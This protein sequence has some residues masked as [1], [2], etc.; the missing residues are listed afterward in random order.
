MN[1]AGL[2]EVK[3][4]LAELPQKELVELCLS[5]A[6]YKKD[7]KE[8]LGFLLFEAHDKP[9]FIREVKT[10]IDVH[11][12]ELVKQPNLYY[13]KKGLRKQLRLLTKYGKYVGDKALTADMLIYF[14]RKLKLSGI[15][16]HK[17]KLIVNLYAQQLK[18]INALVKSFHEDLQAD[19]KNDLEE[20]SE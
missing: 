19:Y 7:N 17:N 8:Y 20:I 6:K 9:A 15:P 5:L 2:Q 1:A 3:K 14:L 16:Y 13:V 4:E 11:F 12:E 10:G 18:K